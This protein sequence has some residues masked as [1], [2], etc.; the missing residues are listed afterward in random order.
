[1]NILREPVMDASAWTAAQMAARDDWVM[2]LDDAARDEIDTALGHAVQN[3]LDP[4]TDG[5]G[6]F[7]LPR[8]TAVLDEVI[9]ELEN[10]RGFVLMRGLDL[11]RY[12]GAEIRTLYAG[13]GAHLGRVITQNSRGD[14]VGEVTDRGNDYGRTAVRGHTSND[15][16]RPHCDSADVVGLLCVHPAASG[17]ESTVASATSIYNAILED[18]PQ[19]LGALCRGFRINLA[20]K[21]PSGDPAECSNHVIPVFSYHAGRLSCRYNQ[22]QIED[23]ASILGTPLSALER[24]AVA[25]VG[26]LAVSDRLRLD[27]DFRRGDLQLLNNHAILHARKA[28]QDGG[29]P[30]SRRLL[31]RMWVNLTQGRPLPAAFADR[32]NTGPRGEV[33][34]TDRSV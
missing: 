34:V 2:S 16:I 20:G 26:E 33:A 15:A 24:E 10:G 32:L 27:M 1:M 28:Y 4:L 11:E 6:A 18:H 17:G 31:L 9:G 3:G 14:R 8:F 30:G 22:K 19:Y 5:P 12:S 23:A 25:C 7:P 13:L 21:G 29:E